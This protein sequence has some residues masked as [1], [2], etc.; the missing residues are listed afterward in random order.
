MTI[1]ILA[2]ASILLT[3]ASPAFA[4]PITLQSEHESTRY[5]RGVLTLTYDDQT[6]D[7]APDELY[8]SYIDAISSLNFVFDSIEYR[9]D[10]S[11]SNGIHIR[12]DRGSI[13]MGATLLDAADRAYTWTY[14]REIRELRLDGTDGLV[15]LLHGGTIE[16][17]IHA[18]FRGS[19]SGADWLT[20][21]TPLHPIAVFEPSPLV[22]L[23]IGLIPLL[24]ARRRGV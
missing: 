21:R 22:L 10:T 7:S 11:A 17:S 6:P 2:L 20:T 23:A 16:E 13:V 12:P 1:R 4:V 24:I 19:I 8:G 3:V 18:I 14:Q 15:E 5:G 9:L